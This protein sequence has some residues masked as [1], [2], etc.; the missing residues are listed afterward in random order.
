MTLEESYNK[1]KAEYAKRGHGEDSW[2]WNDEGKV[3]AIQDYL[4]SCDMTEEDWKFADSVGIAELCQ[5]IIED[6]E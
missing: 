4:S 1:A 3:Y 2:Q 6:N 5:E